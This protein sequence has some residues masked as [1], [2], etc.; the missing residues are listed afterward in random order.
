MATK[1]FHFR[2]DDARKGR[3]D[4]LAEK[5][6]LSVSEILREFIDHGLQA[7]G[8]T[9]AE[10]RALQDRRRKAPGRAGLVLPM[11]PARL[12]AEGEDPLSSYE[13]TFERR[14]RAA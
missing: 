1:L 10:G 7:N 4:A 12:R 9:D 3:L 2:L 11:V 13:R 6:G 8:V 5:L 14:H